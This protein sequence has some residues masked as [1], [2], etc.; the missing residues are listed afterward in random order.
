MTNYPLGGRSLHFIVKEQPNM[1]ASLQK[2]PPREPHILLFSS[3]VRLFR[4]ESGLV[5]LKQKNVAE[6][7]LCNLCNF[8]FALLK[9][10]LRGKPTT[11][12]K[13]SLIEL[14]LSPPYC[15]EAQLEPMQRE[16]ENDA[17]QEMP[18]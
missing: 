12:F 11:I 1:V 6:V 15:E 2:G 17:S 13:I 5:P 10:S 3:H 8:C 14:T 16:R 9:H 7:S 18:R 4:T